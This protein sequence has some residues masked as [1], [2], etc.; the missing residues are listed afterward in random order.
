[1][2]HMQRDIEMQ[3]LLLREQADAWVEQA[4]R[5]H[6]ALGARRHLALVGR[7]SSGHACTYTAY[8]HTLQTGRHPIEVRPW[9]TTQRLPEA[10][11][12]DVLVY[13]YS[14]SGKSTDVAHAAGW[15]RSRG[16]KVLGITN[17]DEEPTNL[18]R[19]SDAMF[20][21][22]VGEEIA[23]PSTKTFT[24]Q[25]FASAALSGYTI[26]PAIEQAAAALEAAYADRVHERLADFIDGGRTVQVVARGPALAA[27]LDGALKLQEAANVMAT[28]Y[29]AAEILH[30]PVGSLSKEDRVLVLEDEPGGGE[31]RQAV[32]TRLVGLG[33]PH[34][35]VTDHDSPAAEHVGISVKMPQERWARTPVLAYLFQA[36]A[37]A[38]AKRRGLDPDQPAGLQKVT[39]T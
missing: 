17:A 11:W 8:L 19:A 20:R 2:I 9:L 32:L 24:A 38:L 25:L 15:L 13:A 28:G 16:A 33:V 34:L 29:S 10:S 12:D 6:E 23:V 35:I 22:G 26:R 1:M 7:G 21:L 3:P 30:G 27:A 14:V 36:A 37:L 39:L 18:G 4:R 5:C 31:S